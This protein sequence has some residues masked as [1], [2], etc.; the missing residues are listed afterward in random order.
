MRSTVYASAAISIFLAYAWSDWIG[1]IVNISIFVIF[2]LWYTRVT[3]LAIRTLTRFKN[4]GTGLLLILLG[5]LLTS[6]I[7]SPSVAFREE[8]SLVGIVRLGSSYDIVILAPLLE[9]VWRAVALSAWVI[10]P[11]EAIFLSSG[12]HALSHS[13]LLFIEDSL[14]I[15]NMFILSSLIAT[16]LM[17]RNGFWAAFLFHALGNI[18]RPALNIQSIL[19]DTSVYLVYWIISVYLILLFAR[20][21]YGAYKDYVQEMN[22]LIPDLLRKHA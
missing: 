15:M 20:M 12:L 10:F 5:W 19:S 6:V 13:K 9:E 2:W 1:V 14:I 18:Y 4:P 16:T 21:A 8:N 11:K 17:L 7:H 22:H 3:S